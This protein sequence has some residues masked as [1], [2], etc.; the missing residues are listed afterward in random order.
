MHVIL[1]IC[2]LL[3]RGNVH[4]F[5]ICSGI[6]PPKQKRYRP[7]V[8][9]AN[10]GFLKTV[11]STEA[12]NG[13]DG[14]SRNSNALS[15]LW[16]ASPAEHNDSMSNEENLLLQINLSMAVDTNATREKT[17]EKIQKYLFTF[18]YAAILP[19]QPLKYQPTELETTGGGVDVI[20]LRKKTGEKG[21][22]DGGLHIMIDRENNE[23]NALLKLTVRRNKKGQTISKIFSEKI[24]VTELLK[25][26]SLQQDKLDVRVE[27]F[28]HRW[29]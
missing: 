4:S 26:I 17:L 20:F 14:Y 11:E 12:K 10:C 25:G 6:I 29:M 3:L 8:V 2:G 24:V 18:P 19:V 13:R 27:S 7:N 16:A 9:E 1:L 22:M 21:S 23:N 5:A 15:I 28:F